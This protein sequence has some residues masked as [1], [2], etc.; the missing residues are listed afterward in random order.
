MEAEMICRDCCTPVIKTYLDMEVGYALPDEALTVD[1]LN[2]F[3]PY[4]E[5][6]PD[7]RVYGGDK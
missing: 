6:P 5:P 1:T 7:A 3:M 2:T 4:H